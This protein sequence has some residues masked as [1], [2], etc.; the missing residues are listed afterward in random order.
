MCS[1]SSQRSVTVDQLSNYRSDRQQPYLVTVDAIDC[2]QSMRQIADSRCDRWRTVDATDGG[3]STRQIEDN[4]C[5]RLR[6]VDATD[7]GPSMLI[8]RAGR[9][10]D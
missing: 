5:D 3:P 7:G 2:G 6:T 4:R 8:L 9:R 1:H 10:C